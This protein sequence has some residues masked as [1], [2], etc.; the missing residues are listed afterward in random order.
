MSFC[1]LRREIV[2][3]ADLPRRRMRMV[4]RLLKRT[5]LAPFL[6]LPLLSC[7]EKKPSAM[8]V[9]ALLESPRGLPDK[10]V[11]VPSALR[12]QTRGDAGSGALDDRALFTV[13]A[14]LARMHQRGLL[15]IADQYSPN[16]DG[17]QHLLT[18][19]PTPD[20]LASGN[21]QP[22]DSSTGSGAT[23][24]ATSGWRLVLARPR[25]VKV[26]PIHDSDSP[27]EKL[28]FGYALAYIDYR[29]VP[30][31]IGAA[32]DQGSP[33]FQELELAQQRSI[34][35]A[36]PLNSTRV[37]HGRAYFTHDGGGAWVVTGT[38][39]PRC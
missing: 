25:L 30:T 15:A 35:A 28:R 32:L 12:V 6:L 24:G 2:L 5:L 8:E 37:Y 11:M 16:G 7:R 38:E 14:V 21:L 1:V 31:D 33:E 36:A 9:T 4:R 22:A 19:Q 18:I 3:Q 20:A 13:D 27:T 23:D 34:A 26:G 29:Y 17:Y 39:C 10:R